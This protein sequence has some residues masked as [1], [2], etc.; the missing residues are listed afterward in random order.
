M[1]AR[2]LVRMAIEWCGI[3]PFMYATS[4]TNSCDRDK[5][6]AH[7]GESDGHRHDREFSLMFLYMEPHMKPSMMIAMAP[8]MSRDM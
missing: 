8:P 6:N 3:I 4:S 1:S 2:S 7:D 5:N